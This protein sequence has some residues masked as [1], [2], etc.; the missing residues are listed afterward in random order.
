MLGNK[1]DFSKQIYQLQ[2]VVCFPVQ[3]LLIYKI[4]IFIMILINLIISITRM[5]SFQ[6]IPETPINCAKI[7]LEF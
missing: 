4:I 6:N 1:H 2:L 3:L 5:L 7:S